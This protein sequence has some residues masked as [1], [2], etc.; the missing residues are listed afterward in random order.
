MTLMWPWGGI[1][2]SPGISCKLAIWLR[3]WPTGMLQ[4]EQNRGYGI[5]VRHTKATP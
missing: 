4:A 5:D 2:T 3:F 1:G